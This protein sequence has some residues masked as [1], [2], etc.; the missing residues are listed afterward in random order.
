MVAM[1]QGFSMLLC[2][3]KTNCMKLRRREFEIEWKKC[4]WI[5]DNWYIFLRMPLCILFY[6]LTLF[7]SLSHFI[8]LLIQTVYIDYR[9]DLHFIFIF[10]INLQVNVLLFSSRLRWNVAMLFVRLRTLMFMPCHVSVFNLCCVWCCAVI[11]T[12]FVCNNFVYLFD[13]D[14]VGMSW[15]ADALSQPLKWNIRPKMRWNWRTS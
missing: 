6:S 9:K 8:S 2:I 15:M 12:S 10:S 14:C 5:T 3:K 4:A 13:R 1:L 11:D 7:L